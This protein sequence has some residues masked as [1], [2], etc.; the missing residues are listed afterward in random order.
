MSF[1]EGIHEIKLVKNLVSLTQTKRY[2][3]FAQ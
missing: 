1:W 2:L 3:L